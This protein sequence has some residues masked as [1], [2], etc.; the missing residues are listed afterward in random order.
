MSRCTAP[1]E[2]PQ[3]WSALLG[4]QTSTVL[5]LQVQFTI[6]LISLKA[7]SFQDSP[8]HLFPSPR[9]VVSPILHASTWMFTV[10]RCVRPG[11]SLIVLLPPCVSHICP[12]PGLAAVGSETQ[13][14]GDL[15]ICLS[16]SLHW[17][18]SGVKS[19]SSGEGAVS[20]ADAFPAAPRTSCFF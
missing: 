10:L 19:P 13:R 17:V 9:G 11:Q 16:Q 18:E 4:A 14:A 1:S 7:G 12:Q 6:V 3:S 5:A 8:I 20:Q 2:F 15:W